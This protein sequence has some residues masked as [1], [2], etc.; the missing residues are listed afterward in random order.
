MALKKYSITIEPQTLN[1]L[2]VLAMFL[3]TTIILNYSARTLASEDTTSQA[4]HDTTLCHIT[5]FDGNDKEIF[6]KK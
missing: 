1:A 6:V 5:T 4:V 2:R 3:R